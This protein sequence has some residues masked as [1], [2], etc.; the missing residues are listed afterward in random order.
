M[1][2]YFLFPFKYRLN[3]KNVSR[4]NYKIND[5]EIDAAEIRYLF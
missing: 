2:K 5:G 1:V 4:C 3:G